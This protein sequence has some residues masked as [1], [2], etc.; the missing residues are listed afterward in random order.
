LNENNNTNK[1]N[2]SQARAILQ[3]DISSA[4][5][6]W[7]QNLLTNISTKDFKQNPKLGWETIIKINE[8][9]KA[10]HKKTGKL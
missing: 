4:K 6:K 10:Q 9:C 3:K 7:L 8:K 5:N 1:E 2:L